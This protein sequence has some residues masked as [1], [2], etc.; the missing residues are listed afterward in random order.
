MQKGD[1]FQMM[2]TTED[3]RTGMLLLCLS[4]YNEN[5]VLYTVYRV[6][7]TKVYTLFIETLFHSEHALKRDAV[8][9]GKEAK[10]GKR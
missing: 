5:G 6:N 3:G 4:Y 8:K 10:R 2:Y 9:A 7:K 1:P